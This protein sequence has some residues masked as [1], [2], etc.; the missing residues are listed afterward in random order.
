MDKNDFIAI[1]KAETEDHL[2][3]LNTGIVALEKKPDDLELVKELNREAHTMKGSARAMGYNDIEEV[4]H[5]IEDIFDGISQGKMVFYPST[6]DK[7]FSGLDIIKVIIEKIAKGEEAD[8]DI[9][10][11]CKELEGAVKEVSLEEKK[12]KAEYPGKRQKADRQEEKGGKTKNKKKEKKKDKAGPAP[13]RKIKPSQLIEEYIRVP[14]SRVNK[15]LNLVGELV[16]NKMNSTQKI[17]ETKK[18][19]SASKEIHKRMFDL[20]EKIKVRLS[21]DDTDEIFKQI[22]RNCVEIENLKDGAFK[23]YEHISTESLHLD[24]VIDELQTR[25]KE[26]RMLPCATIFES[27]PRLVRDIAA[28]EKKEI[29]LEMSGERTELDKKVLERIKSPLIH[30]LRNCIDH[31]IEEPDERKSAD[32]PGAGTISIS[33]HHEA[34]KV[35]ITVE[36]DGKGIDIDSIRTT[37]VKKGIVSE[38]GLEK[39]SEREILN[40]VF[41][42]GYS[43]SPIITDISGRGIGL[44]VVRRD[45]ESAKG[46]VKLETEKGKGTKISLTLPLTI[47]IIKVLLIKSLDNLFAMPVA[48]VEE[49]LKIKVKD[50]STVE[51][52]MAADVRGHV[53]PMVK[54]NEILGLQTASMDDGRTD[55]EEVFVIV[56]TSMD[57]RVGFIVDEIVCEE[58]IF[59]KGLGEHLGKIKNVSG[60][61]I[62]GTGEV[63]VI[64]NV[65]DLIEASHLSHPAA[66]PQRDIPKEKKMGKKILV[67][68]DALTTREL[69]KSIL[70]GQ[71]Y[72]VATAVDGLD[73]L[74]KVGRERFDLI[75]SD[76]QMPRMD[77][78]EFCRTLKNMD[79]YK[80]IPVVIVSALGKEEDK[81]HGIEVGAQAYIVKTAFD[82]SNLI[83]TI[84]RLVG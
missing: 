21:L 28:K 20:R 9:A 74:D 43:T 6:A 46:Q 39:M 41:A 19:A 67:V 83:D 75:V 72:K 32:K 2:T 62:L 81:R 38:E 68:E 7:I 51:G 26:I 11:V 47:A 5:R 70:E 1:F 59:I 35:V 45:I 80:D 58:E 55:K 37:A 77:G 84:A 31:G 36:D 61:T 78:F 17:N 10:D 69:E 16:I 22:H 40:L 48:S 4:A 42:N 24:P 56:A 13:N 29:T 12:A 64:L 15:L 76:V 66:L 34:G 44:D 49:S 65:Q 79:E 63:I 30:I 23:L 73:G 50:I 82:Q 53:V 57:K 27:F 54:L 14:V 18:I 52:N 60:A 71:G 33:A 8:T 3:K 25:V